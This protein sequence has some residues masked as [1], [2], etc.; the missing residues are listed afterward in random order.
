MCCSLRMGKHDKRKRNA[1]AKRRKKKFKNEKQTITSEQQGEND[2]KNYSPGK[3]PIEDKH[4][5]NGT[6]CN[7]NANSSLSTFESDPLY[8]AWIQYQ[9]KQFEFY[10]LKRNPLRNYQKCF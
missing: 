5:T 1:Y 4:Q 2:F 6:E 10:R 9:E 8:V 7:I 3:K